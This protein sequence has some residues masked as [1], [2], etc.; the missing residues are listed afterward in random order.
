VT[1]AWK[2]AQGITF[3]FAACP[4]GGAKLPGPGGTGSPLDA[5]FDAPPEPPPEPPI[6]L[7]PPPFPAPPMDPVVTDDPPAPPDPVAV[8]VGA[9]LVPEELPA[10]PAPAIHPTHELPIASQ[11]RCMKVFI[12]AI[13]PESRSERE[14]VK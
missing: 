12:A 2:P 7:P 4:D 1:A 10:H 13:L 5:P 8:L 11:R 6:A 3:R 14:A 9:M